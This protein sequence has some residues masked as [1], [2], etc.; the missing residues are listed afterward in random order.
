MTVE[1]R[2]ASLEAR[3]AIRELRYAYAAY[4]DAGEWEEWGRLF[5][6]DAVFEA[7]DADLIVGREAITEFGRVT[8][9]DLFA[10]SAH[11]M[12]NPRIEVDGDRATGHWYVTVF[13]AHPD[14]TAGWH[15]GKYDETYILEGGTWL[16]DRVTVSIDYETAG[17]LTWTEMY[18]ERRGRDVLQVGF[19]A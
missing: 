14:G 2:L 5:S 19:P 12:A 16:F 15:G 8:I 4:L 7:T 13:F 6:K 18:D 11:F 3:E 10:H 1:D 17:K 9:A